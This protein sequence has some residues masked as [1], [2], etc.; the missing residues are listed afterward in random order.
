VREPVGS[1]EHNLQ[2]FIELERNAKLVDEQDLKK[3]IKEG[4]T[5]ASMAPSHM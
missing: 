5:C 2:G 4:K 3:K 1:S